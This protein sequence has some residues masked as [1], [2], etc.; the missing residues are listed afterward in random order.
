MKKTVD[1]YTFYWAGFEL[2]VTP[3]LDKDIDSKL[4]LAASG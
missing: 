4:A 2:C 1:D 3:A